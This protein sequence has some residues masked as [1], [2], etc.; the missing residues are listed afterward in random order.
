MLLPLTLELG[1]RPTTQPLITGTRAG[2][3]LALGRQADRENA[4]SP[5]TVLGRQADGERMCIHVHNPAV[6]SPM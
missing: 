2:A 3:T 4:I 6:R 1:R 5:P